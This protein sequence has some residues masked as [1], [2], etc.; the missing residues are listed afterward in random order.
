MP[1]IQ[2]PVAF[3][4]IDFLPGFPSLSK[5]DCNPW[6]TAFKA[7]ACATP[8]TVIGRERNA[9][10][11]AGDIMARAIASSSNRPAQI[12]GL[13]GCGGK[14]GCAGKCGGL[15]HN[16]SMGGIGS[17]DFSLNSTSI[18]DTITSYLPATVATSLPHISNWI[19][20]L[21][22]GGFLYMRSKGGR[23]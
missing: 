22:V 4:S 15:G 16:D 7:G 6:S 2:K 5:Y 11:Y 20:Y 23:R 3:D 8:P 14:C 9:N 19:L 21:A 13:G 1:L 12:E 18:A 17:I 10:I